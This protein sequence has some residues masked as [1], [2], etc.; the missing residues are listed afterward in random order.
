MVN[1]LELPRHLQ[2]L[3]FED[4]KD[5]TENGRQSAE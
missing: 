3:G 5:E 2:R 4:G 1:R